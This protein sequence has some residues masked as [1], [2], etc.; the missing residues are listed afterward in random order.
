MSDADDVNDPNRKCR[1]P[2]STASCGGRCD[3]VYG[4]GG[5]H[6]C[7]RDASH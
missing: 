2:C 3:K 6:T 7:D 4:H 5:G 1:M